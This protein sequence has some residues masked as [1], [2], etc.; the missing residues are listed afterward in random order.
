M[1]T[2]LPFPMWYVSRSVPVNLRPEADSSYHPGPANILLPGFLTFAM[3][4]LSSS[5]GMNVDLSFARHEKITSSFSELLH[6]P[7]S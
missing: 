3:A 4:H 5:Q 1:A 6:A 7:C 2:I